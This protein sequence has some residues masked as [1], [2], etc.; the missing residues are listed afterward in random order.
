[1]AETTGA[2]ASLLQHRKVQRP[3]IRQQVWKRGRRGPGIEVQLEGGPAGNSL[4]VSSDLSRGLVEQRQVG[5]G[6]RR[7]TRAQ[8]R[9]LRKLCCH[10]FLAAC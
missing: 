5:Q 9:E 10:R 2:Q 6:T 8:W 1:M 4:E 3:R 7:E